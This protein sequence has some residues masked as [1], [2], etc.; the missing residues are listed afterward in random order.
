MQAYWEGLLGD[1]YPVWYLKLYRWDRYTSLLARELKLPPG[2]KVLDCACGGCGEPALTLSKL[3]WKITASDGSSKM[4]ATALQRL[5]DY[6]NVDLVEKP[7]PWSQL[8]AQFDK[9]TF[10]C[11]VCAAN[12]ISHIQPLELTQSLGQMMEILKPG[13]WLVIDVKKFIDGKEVSKDGQSTR[14]MLDFG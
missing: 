3:P 1:I 7:T 12:S 2:S 4:L 8:T 11:V 10:D 6:H 13:G 9:G 5:K 14:S